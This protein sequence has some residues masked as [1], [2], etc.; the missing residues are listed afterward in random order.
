MTTVTEPSTLPLG[1]RIR[2]ARKRAGLSQVRFAEMLGTSQRHVVRWEYGE[3]APGD[4]Y[5]QR[6]AEATGQPAELFASDEQES[7]R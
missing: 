6:I 4:I 3:H 2:W 5:R 7:E 1:E